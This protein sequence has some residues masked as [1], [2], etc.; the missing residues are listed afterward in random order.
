M[1]RNL[2]DPA[3]YSLPFLVAFLVSV[4]M[5]MTDTNLRTNFGSMSSGY[6]AHWYAVLVMAI[7]DLVG[8]ALLIVVRSRT[9]VKLGVVGSGLISLALV[10]DVFTY[11]QV[12]F[13]SASSFANY[14]FGVTYYGGDIRYLYDLLLAVYIVTFLTGIVLLLV[15]R[16]ARPP[17]RSGSPT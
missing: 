7:V 14:L 17:T 9:I 15:S 4:V 2:S 3:V 10:A 1:A 11:S 8:A 12:G 6:Y 5:L 16:S 13:S